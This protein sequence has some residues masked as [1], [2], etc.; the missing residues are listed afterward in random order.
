MSHATQ[1]E[2]VDPRSPRGAASQADVLRPWSLGAR[3]ASLRRSVPQDGVPPSSLSAGDPELLCVCVAASVA[4]FFRARAQTSPRIAYFFMEGSWVTPA[5]EGM[6]P[7]LAGC[8]GK[9]A[10]RSRFG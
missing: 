5:C 4:R 2:F 7:V 8:G 1:E 9:C 3:I 6:L 10:R